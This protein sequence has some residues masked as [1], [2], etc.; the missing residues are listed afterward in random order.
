MTF[1]EF[2]VVCQRADGLLTGSLKREVRAELELHAADAANYTPET[3]AALAKRVTRE[4][5]L[6][7][8]LH[9]ATAIWKERSKPATKSVSLLGGVFGVPCQYE[10]P[11]LIRYRMTVNPRTT[12]WLAGR[13]VQTEQLCWDASVIRID[14]HTVP[15]VALT[16][17]ASCFRHVQPSRLFGRPLLQ[18][19]Q[20]VKIPTW[21][22][23]GALVTGWETGITRDLDAYRSGVKQL[24]RATQRELVDQPFV[25]FSIPGHNSRDGKERPC[26][27]VCPWS[28]ACRDDVDDFR[29]TVAR[30]LSFTYGAEGGGRARIASLDASDVT[31]WAYNTQIVVRNPRSSR[32]EGAD[33]WDWA[34]LG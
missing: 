10:T 20:G 12:L 14:G 34:D 24:D 33:D 13:G 27:W 18:K 19:E 9:T 22:G 31:I 29:A 6:L 17:D 3:G 28:P 11:T 5:A 25:V 26:V 4:L 21:S 15:V 8:T 16:A 30:E 7:D 23:S 2:L 32:I 1:E